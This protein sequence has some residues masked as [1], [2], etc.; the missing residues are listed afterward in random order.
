MKEA[1]TTR[2]GN[3][4]DIEV[5][6]P[7][8]A[9]R[10]VL[11]AAGRGGSPDR[12][13]GL[14]NALANH[15]CAVVAP[16]FDMMPPIPS[17]ADLLARIDRIRCAID[18]L[19]RPDRPVVGIGHSIGASILLLLNGVEG[20]TKGGMEHLSV[21]REIE[22]EKLLLLAPALDFFPDPR[23]LEPV[24]ARVW[25]WLGRKD[26]MVPVAKVEAMQANARPGHEIEIFIDELAGHFTCM[27]ELPPQVKD[28][29]PDRQSY[30]ERLAEQVCRVI[31]Q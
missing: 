17:A 16:H 28:T 2:D 20:W 7:A 6:Q 22:F 14:I 13:R 8:N 26:E 21:Q 23:A 30:L 31:T 5:E 12:H 1:V 29:H 3:Q 19:H 11:F 4:F 27:D 9:M 10:T 24:V 25:F 15:R 18:A